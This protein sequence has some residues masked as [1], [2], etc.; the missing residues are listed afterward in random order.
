MVQLPP[1]GC[2]Y[3]PKAR[4]VAQFGWYR[5]QPV[6]VQVQLYQV[7]RLPSSGGIAPDNRLR[8]RSSTTRFVRSPSW[9]G[10]GPVNWLLVRFSHSRFA[11]FPLGRYRSRQLVLGEIQSL[12]FVRRT[13]LAELDPRGVSRSRSSVTRPSL[14][15]VTPYQKRTAEPIRRGRPVRAVRGFVQRH[16]RSVRLGTPASSRAHSISAAM[17][18]G[19]GVGVGVGSGRGAGVGVGGAWAWVSGGRGRGCRRGRRASGWASG[20]RGWA[21]A[22]SGSGRGCRGGRGR[23]GRRGGRRVHRRGGRRV[24]RRGG[25]R[26]HRRGQLRSGR[27]VGG[28]HRRPPAQKKPPRG[29]CGGQ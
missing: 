28:A 19:V 18:S 3:S 11:R 2:A 9:G 4:E 26:A 6:L 20:R 17:G 29:G 8:G 14:S 27:G 7:P 22:V 12:R 23:G 16:E 21:W 15:A 10:I 5:C 24:H 1:A 13:N 25:R